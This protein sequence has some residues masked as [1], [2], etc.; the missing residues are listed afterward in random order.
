MKATKSELRVL[1]R[2]MREDLRALNT[3]LTSDSALQVKLYITD[4]LGVI[5][6]LADLAE[7]RFSIEID[8][9]EPQDV[10]YACEEDAVDADEEG[11]YED[12][13]EEYED[14]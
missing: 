12:D 11:E 13:D 5:D 9:P 2:R 1:M 8:S 3:A 4:M 7:E 10:D 14:E 6:E